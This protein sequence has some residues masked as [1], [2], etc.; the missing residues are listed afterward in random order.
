MPARARRARPEPAPPPPHERDLLHVC[1]L[2]AV[3]ALFARDRA[4]V[5]RLFF[6]PRLARRLLAARQALARARKP[7]REAGADELARIAGTLHHGGV[8]AVARPLP[9][10]PFDPHEAA[11][12]AAEGR[13]LLVLDGI[14]NPHN[15]GAPPSSG[16]LASCFPTGQSR[17]CR[18]APPIA[19]PRG[20]LKA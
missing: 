12:W 13:V 19:W 6:E 1:G 14:G 2:A 20:R 15:L 3:E 10:R 4:R 18:P 9:L 7:Y 11:G 8:V 5:E 16:S 17:P